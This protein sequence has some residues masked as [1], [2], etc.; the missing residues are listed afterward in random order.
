MKTIITWF[1]SL[2]KEQKQYKLKSS[3]KIFSWII[4]VDLYPMGWWLTA[5]RVEYK[6]MAIAFVIMFACFAI[7]NFFVDEMPNTNTSSNKT[8]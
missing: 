6:P 7:F 4:L 8:K 1:K 5:G 2:S 3:L